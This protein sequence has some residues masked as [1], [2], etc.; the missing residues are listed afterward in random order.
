LLLAASYKLVA[1]GTGRLLMDEL[2]N[3]ANFYTL[4]VASVRFVG[5]TSRFVVT[6]KRGG[7][8]HDERAVFP[9]R[10]L[11]GLT[12]MALVWSALGLGF[13]VTE[14]AVGAGVA[15]FWAL[16]NLTLM[17]VVAAFA[18]RPAQKRQAVRFRA[19]VPVELL[20]VPANGW[21]GVTLDLAETG[22]TLLWPRRLAAGTRLKLRLQLGSRPLDCDGAIVSVQN[23]VRSDWMAHGVCFRFHQPHDVDHLADALYNMAVPEIFARLTRPSRIVRVAR[24]AVSRL[25]GSARFRAPRYEAYLPMRVQTRTGDEW[26]ATT[27]DLSQSGLSLVSPHALGPGRVVRLILRSPEGEWSSLATVVRSTRMPGAGGSTETW[28]LGLRLDGQHDVVG[29]R[30][31]LS[32]ESVA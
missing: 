1:R 17:T 21:L 7:A 15:A 5:G 16:Y 32:A 26:L 28:L 3:M 22:C 25:A 19:S 6:D 31:I 9:H 8:G 14:D 2:F 11:I 10:V 18:Q 4:L 20:D 27:R 23:R 24:A 30:H 13:G 12:V 29:L